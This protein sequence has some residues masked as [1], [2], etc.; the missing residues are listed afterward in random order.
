MRTTVDELQSRI[1]AI[2]DQDPDT[3]NID[4]NDYALRLKYLNIAQDSWS[5]YYDWQCLYKEYNMLVSTASGNASIVMPGDFRKLASYPLIATSDGS[6]EFPETRPQ[7][8]GNFNSYQKRVELLG[9]PY[10]N[11]ILRVYGVSLQSGASV[12]VPYYSSAGSLATGSDISVVPDPEFLVKRT[13]AYIWEARGDELFPQ[14]KREA[15]SILKNMLERENVPS[16][17]FDNRVKTVEE[18]RYSFRLGRD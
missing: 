5:Q 8:Q 1:A 4:T 9:N 12:K 15:E 7:E 11:Y 18:R 2:T 6:Y 14:M 16:E 13:V 10:S 17:A 3:N